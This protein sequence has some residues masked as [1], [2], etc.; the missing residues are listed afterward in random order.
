[1]QYTPWPPSWVLE[2]EESWGEKQIATNRDGLNNCTRSR[3]L[4]VR[5][6]SNSGSA[7]KTQALQAMLRMI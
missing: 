3:S 5:E 6:K 7:R 1:M 4:I 2:V